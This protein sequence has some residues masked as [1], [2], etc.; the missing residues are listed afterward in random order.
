MFAWVKK[1][2]KQRVIKGIRRHM[3]W[4][5]HDISEM[6]DEEIEAATLRFGEMVRKTGI[7]AQEANDSLKRGLNGRMMNDTSDNELSPL[8]DQ[9]ADTSAMLAVLLED[10]YDVAPDTVKDRICEEIGK[11][12]QCIHDAERNLTPTPELTSPTLTGFKQ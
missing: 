9:L 11:I 5:G 3:A 6:S 1:W 2:R 12:N 8:I 10:I 4:F 7:T